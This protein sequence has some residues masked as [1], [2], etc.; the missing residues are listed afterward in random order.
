MRTRLMASIAIALMIVPG[1]QP[2]LLAGAQDITQGAQPAAPADVAQSAQPSAPAG[3]GRL[4]KRAANRFQTAAGRDRA[5]APVRYQ[6]GG[7]RISDDRT[8]WRIRFQ[9]RTP[10]QLSARDSWTSAASSWAWRRRSWWLA[11]GPIAVS[12]MASG[13]G[14]TAASAAGGGFSLFGLG[15]TASLAVLGAA[16]AAAVTAVVATKSDAAVPVAWAGPAQCRPILLP[17]NLPSNCSTAS[18][19]SQRA[20]RAGAGRPS[21]ASHQVLRTLDRAPSERW[22]VSLE[23]VTRWSSPSR[24]SP[25]ANGTGR[26]ASPTC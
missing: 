6:R 19:R 25:P 21:R 20:R 14:V 23:S 7:R 10:G 9:R 11:E 18:A 15:P 16:G 4:L 1:L 5:A 12:V 26:I 8:V 24:K 13:L 22:L 17:R 2:V 3:I